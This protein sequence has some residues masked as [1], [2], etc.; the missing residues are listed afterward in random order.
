M[1]ETIGAQPLQ[2]LNAAPARNRIV[3]RRRH[4]LDALLIIGYLLRCVQLR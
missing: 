3:W 4:H 2:G 1:V